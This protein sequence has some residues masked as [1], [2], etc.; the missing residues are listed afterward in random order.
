MTSPA[1]NLLLSVDSS[2]VIPPQCIA[3]LTM[4]NNMFCRVLGA[5]T[6]A[7]FRQRSLAS[8]ATMR[9]GSKLGLSH[10]PY[11]TYASQIDVSVISEE[12]R[13]PFRIEE[14]HL[15]PEQ[16]HLI[17]LV[18]TG[19]NV[20]YTGSAGSGKSTVLRELIRQ[21]QAMNKVVRVVAPTGRAAL[22]LNGETTW[23]YL[24]WTPNHLKYSLDRLKTEACRETNMSRFENTDVLVI[25]EISLIDNH[26]LERWNEVMKEARYQPNLEVQP[27]FG[28]VQLIVTGDFCQL[29]PIRPFQHCIECGLELVHG[30]SPHGMVHVCSQH[31][32]YYDE[33]KWAFCSKAWRECNFHHVHLK[34]IHRQTDPEFIRIL[35]KLRVR[36]KLSQQDID[37]LMNH[38]C[39]TE[40]AVRLYP[41][42]KETASVNQAAFRRLPGVNHTYWCRDN[43]IWRKK[44]HPH[45]VYKA[46]R[47]VA[48]PQ[49]KGPLIALQEHRL[50]ECV[51][52]K[53]GMPVVLLSNL[54][55]AEGLCNGSQGVVCGFE[56]YDHTKKIN[57]T[58]RRDEESQLVTKEIDRF[59][60]DSGVSHKVWPIVRFHNGKVRTIYAK[61]SMTALGDIPPYSLL[62]RTQIPLAPAWAMTVHKS[63]GL[64]LDRVIVDLTN[65][66]EQGQIYVALSRVRTL[67]GLKI[68]GDSK[69]LTIAI[70]GND[71]VIEFHREK[72]GDLNDILKSGPRRSNM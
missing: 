71:K 68:E 63:Q 31:G 58:A 13:S 9:T 59:I 27:P 22:Q 3:L 42:R 51:Q 64:T 26:F 37:I 18:K 5:T 70:G 65:V 16:E 32:E 11:S 52:L 19:C 69:A 41:T 7:S 50:E 1:N 23:R 60:H 61:C 4:R 14:P 46:E 25:D 66:F 30:D 43:F 35:H 20:F 24:G 6:L 54:D 45:L 15:C 39:E 38:P 33:D 67:S 44:Q 49:S 36:T 12:S 57:A 48:G 55:L 62:T 40:N 72:F 47:K 29:P 53:E 17:D 56:E 28:G 34:T 2:I 21:L 8:F 10:H